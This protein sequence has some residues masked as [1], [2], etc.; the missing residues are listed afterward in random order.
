LLTN[1]TLSKRIWRE[2]FPKLRQRKNK[3]SGKTTGL[4]LKKVMGRARKPIKKRYIYQDLDFKNWI[5]RAKKEEKK[6]LKPGCFYVFEV[7]NW[8]TG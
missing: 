4:I 5:H 1:W 6:I 7:R 3:G 2:Q 8:L